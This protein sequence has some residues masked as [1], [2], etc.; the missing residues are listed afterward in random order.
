MGEWTK[1]SEY[2][3]SHPSG[4]TIAKCYV[5]GVPRYVLWEGDTRKN[6]FNDVRDA[7]RE[8]SRLTRVEQATERGGDAVAPPGPQE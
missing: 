4:W 5:Q 2:C 3:L 7:M 1:E 8:H 6:Q